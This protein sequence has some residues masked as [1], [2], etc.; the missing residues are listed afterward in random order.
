[1]FAEV[2]FP[3]EVDGGDVGQDVLEVEAGGAN[4]EAVDAGC[5][6]E[7]IELAKDFAHFGGGAAGYGMAFAVGDAGDDG[8]ENAAAV[9]DGGADGELEIGV[10]ELHGS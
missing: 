6:E 1:M 9:D 5:G 4:G 10:D 8:F 7:R 2:L 3:G